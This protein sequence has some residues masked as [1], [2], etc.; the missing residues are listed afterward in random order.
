MAAS[1]TWSSNLRVEGRDDFEVSKVLIDMVCMDLNDFD[2]AR[3]WSLTRKVTVA[4]I[5]KGF[6]LYG[7]KY[8][9]GC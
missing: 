2:A 7:D 3:T 4:A 6:L 1:S 9:G 8:L 5:M